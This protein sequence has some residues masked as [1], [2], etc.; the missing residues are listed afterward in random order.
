[1]KKLDNAADKP[2]LHALK[3]AEEGNSLLESPLPKTANILTRTAQPDDKLVQEQSAETGPIP[4]MYNALQDR[5]EVATEQLELRSAGLQKLHK[6]RD[7]HVSNQIEIWRLGWLRLG[8]PQWCAIRPPSP[9][10]GATK[11]TKG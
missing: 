6:M 4:V 5:V 3:S 2:L 7:S 8:K 11:K 9:R 1:M 10:R